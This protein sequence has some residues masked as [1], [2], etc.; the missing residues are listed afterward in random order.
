MH[1]FSHQADFALFKLGISRNV[2]PVPSIFWTRFT[3]EIGMSEV[4]K[5]STFWS[6]KCKKHVFF[7]I[8]QEYIR[9]NRI[10][11]NLCCLF[12]YVTPG[13]SQQNSVFLKIQ[14][15]LLVPVRNAENISNKRV[16][17]R[18]NLKKHMKVHY[19]GLGQTMGPWLHGQPSQPYASSLMN[20]SQPHPKAE[21][22]QLP[23]TGRSSG[24]KLHLTNITGISYFQAFFT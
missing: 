14:P 18:G 15:W 21:S 20:D 9:V 7:E 13:S 10:I 19:K 16:C 6:K 3:K 17:F 24:S 2:T 5:N 1:C 11:Y 23:E 4:V 12:R 22:G 8:M